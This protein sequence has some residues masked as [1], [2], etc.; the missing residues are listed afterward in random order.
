[1]PWTFSKN[2][3]SSAAGLGRE[4][5]I[6]AR[7][8]LGSL[9]LKHLNQSMQTR[10]L[11]FVNLDIMMLRPEVTLTIADELKRARAIAEIGT[12]LFL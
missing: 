4:V 7:I 9:N 12:H 8:R 5:M 11:L 6:E 1:M 10:R 3:L 2:I